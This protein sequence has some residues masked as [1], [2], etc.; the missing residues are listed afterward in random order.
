MKNLSQG[1]REKEL[2]PLGKSACTRGEKWGEGIDGKNGS[3]SGKDI[4][5]NDNG[6]RAETYEEKTSLV[7]Q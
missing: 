1:K 2:Q 7:P 5:R 4:M 3:G 6:G